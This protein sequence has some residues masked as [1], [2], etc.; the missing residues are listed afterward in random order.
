MWIGE[1][2]FCDLMCFAFA[3]DG[4]AVYTGD[5]AGAV[6][7]W[8][9]H[10]GECAELLAP[11]PLPQRQSIWSLAVGRGGSRLFVP[12]RGHVRVLELPG[13]K[14]AGRLLRTADVFPTAASSAD[15]RL[16]ATATNREGVAVWDAE[17]LERVELAG[18]LGVVKQVVA[19]AFAEDAA[20]LLVVRR[21]SAYPAV[22]VWDTTTGEVARALATTNVRYPLFAVSADGRT[23]AAVDAAAADTVWVCDA[24]TGAERVRVRHARPVAGLALHPAGTFLAVTDGTRDVTLW[25]T[26]TGAKAAAWN[27]G[28]GKVRPVA[29]APDGLTCAVGG[30]GKLAVFDVDL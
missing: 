9:R 5:G 13:G 17:T 14:T 11:Q 29:F 16:I 25:G 4:S 28:I 15:G 7:A 24:A 3:P 20:H 26:A 10:T 8:D 18:P 30:A 2:S 21:P 1:T 27:W 19:V 12:R 22:A 23:F 6:L